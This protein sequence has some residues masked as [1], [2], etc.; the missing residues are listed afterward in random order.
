[1]K[2]G[3]YC[4]L[5]VAFSIIL[6]FSA[7]IMIIFLPIALGATQSATSLGKLHSLLYF[8]GISKVYSTEY[9]VPEIIKTSF[10]RGMGYT[11]VFAIV[12]WPCW[13]HSGI[14]IWPWCSQIFRLFYWSR[15]GALR[16]VTFLLWDWRLLFFILHAC[17]G[18]LCCGSDGNRSLWN[19]AERTWF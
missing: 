11:I 13:W 7:P 5:I 8:I 14:N 6:M 12:G 18:V 4:G 16:T 19:C 2:W 3:F 15:N 17:H 9:L 10:V 1:M